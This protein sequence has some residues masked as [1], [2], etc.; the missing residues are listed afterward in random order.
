MQPEMILL[1]EK[2][3]LIENAGRGEW[4]SERAKVGTSKGARGER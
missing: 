1:P 2:G 4:G 3:C